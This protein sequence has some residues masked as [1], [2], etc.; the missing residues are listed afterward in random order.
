[1]RFDNQRGDAAQFFVHV[2]PESLRVVKLVNV[3]FS[4]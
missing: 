1:M 2:V 3:A 4:F